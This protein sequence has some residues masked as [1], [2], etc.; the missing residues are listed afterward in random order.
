MPRRGIRRSS[1]GGGAGKANVGISNDNGGTN[2]QG[3]SNDNGG[4]NPH[5]G[6]PRVPDQ[7]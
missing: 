1:G 7:R 4:T 5:A 3:I 6:R 2:P